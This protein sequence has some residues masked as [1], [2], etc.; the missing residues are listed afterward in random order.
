M[1][2]AGR[3]DLS[4]RAIRDAL[5]RVGCAVHDTSRLGGGFPD[6]LVCT[7]QEELFLFEVKAERGKLTASQQRFHVYFPVHIVKTVD[8]ALRIV[9]ALSAAKAHDANT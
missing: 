6:M 7:A 9:G 3:T 5:R 8:E 2:R 1:R 4:H